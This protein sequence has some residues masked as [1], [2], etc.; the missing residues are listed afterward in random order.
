MGVTVSLILIIKWH[1]NYDHK[2]SRP[3]LQTSSGNVGQSRKFNSKM[4]YC[5]IC[6]CQSFIVMIR[7]NVH[8]GYKRCSSLSTFKHNNTLS[9]SQLKNSCTCSSQTGLK[10]IKNDSTLTDLKCIKNDITQTVL[11][12]IILYR[13][14]LP[15]LGLLIMCTIH[16]P[17]TYL[18]R[19]PFTPPDLFNMST[20][21]RHTPDLHRTGGL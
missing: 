21:H 9:M 19:P 14:T 15:K 1:L 4:K 3:T 13:M 20:I 18:I 11:K 6:C 2:E 16:T 12:Y 8:H 10:C 7:L 17:Q 5:L